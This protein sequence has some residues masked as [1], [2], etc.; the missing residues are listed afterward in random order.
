MRLTPDASGV[1]ARCRE[2]PACEGRGATA[3]EAVERLR[4]ALL[5]WLEACPCDTTTDS[6]LV[7]EVEPDPR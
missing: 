6:G 7:L 4:A 5:F 2:V 1:V 3:E